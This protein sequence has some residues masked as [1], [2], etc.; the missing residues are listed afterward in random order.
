[1]YDLVDYARA[2]SSDKFSCEGYLRQ[3]A[4]ESGCRLIGP[5]FKVNRDALVFVVKKDGTK[6]HAVVSLSGLEMIQNATDE[7]VKDLINTRF[8]NALKTLLKIGG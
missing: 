5:D 1:M 8:G 7:S 6:G 4:K 2:A 3:K